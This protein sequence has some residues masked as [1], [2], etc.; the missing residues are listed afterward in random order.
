MSKDWKLVIVAF[1]VLVGGAW[2]AEE[3]FSLFTVIPL[4]GL[5]GVAYF[6]LRAIKRD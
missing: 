1:V 2:L 4:A 6:G 3:V 5:V